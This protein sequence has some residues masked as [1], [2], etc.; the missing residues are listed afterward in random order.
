MFFSGAIQTKKFLHKVAVILCGNA[1]VWHW[2]ENRTD[3]AWILDTA[4]QTAFPTFLVA[5]MFC[6]TAG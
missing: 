6:F 2:L 5:H 4:V 3:L 1:F